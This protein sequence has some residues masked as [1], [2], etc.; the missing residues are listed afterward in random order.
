MLSVPMPIC[1]GL[2]IK[3]R[4]SKKVKREFQ[5]SSYKRKPIKTKRALRSFQRDFGIKKVSTYNRWISFRLYFLNQG[6]FQ[7]LPKPSDVLGGGNQLAQQTS[8]YIYYPGPSHFLSA[9]DLE[10]ISPFQPE[11]ITELVL[12]FIYLGG[13]T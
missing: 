4:Q 12:A 8:R 10:Q 5:G 9:T 7:L 13:E 11:I 2:K 1:Q 3:N 6:S